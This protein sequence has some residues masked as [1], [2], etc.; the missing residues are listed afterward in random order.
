[1]NKRKFLGFGL[2]LTA[3]LLLVGTGAAAANSLRHGRGPTNWEE[4]RNYDDDQMWGPMHGFGWDTDQE[5]RFTP[6]HTLMVESLAEISELRVEE[7][8]ERIDN[9]E[10]L[11]TIAIDAGVSLED[12]YQMMFDARRSDLE[13]AGKEGLP[14]EEGYQWMFDNMN[15]FEGQS[16]YGGFHGLYSSEYQQNYQLNG[17][18][19]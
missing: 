4:E 1:M 9:G 18:R 19:K 14:Y 5:T 13:G 17:R 16:F 7:I 2:I 12:F 11:Y 3:V 8:K 6:F 15:E 10:A